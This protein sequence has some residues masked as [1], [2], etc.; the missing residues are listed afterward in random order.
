M[1]AGVNNKRHMVGGQDDPSKS[2]QIHQRDHNEG[3]L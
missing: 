3:D 1:H 2:I